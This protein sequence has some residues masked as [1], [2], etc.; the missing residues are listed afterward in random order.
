MP[1]HRTSMRVA[2]SG[3]WAPDQCTYNHIPT[4]TSA[5]CKSS[6]DPPPGWSLFIS[7]QFDGGAYQR[8]GA[9]LRRGGLFDLVK[10]MVSVL[11][12]KTRI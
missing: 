10:T 3:L 12:K 11:H 9:Y 4:Y 6:V 7:N 1:R 8:R 5:Y 2:R